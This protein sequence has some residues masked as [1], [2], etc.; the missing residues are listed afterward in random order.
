MKVGSV[1]QEKALQQWETLRTIY[2]QL[3]AEV[4]LIPQQKH[5]PDMVFTVDQ[6][7]IKNKTILLSSFRHPERQ[8]ETPLFQE[9]F[10]QHGFQVKT[11]P[12]GIYLEG[13]DCLHWNKHLFLGYGFRSDKAATEEISN[14][15]DLPTIPLQLVNDRFY[16]L[17]ASLFILNDEVAFCYPEAFVA[18][19]L[20]KL[21][22]TIPHLE[23]FSSEQAL[24]FAANTFVI[25]KSVIT[26]SADQRF[27]DSIK[28][29]GYSPIKVEMSEYL[30]S[31]GGIHCLSLDLTT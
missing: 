5:L 13:G 12:K 18:E 4:I 29:L 17:D 22:S 31:G 25:E 16:H 19:S 26:S 7:V 14:L 3:D 15:L 8:G 23:L 11:L 10:L 24:S 27:H 28:K 20:Q 1:N 2:Q 6:G 9:W 30:K 21:H